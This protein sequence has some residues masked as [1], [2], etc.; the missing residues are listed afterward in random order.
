MRYHGYMLRLSLFGLAC[1]VVLLGLGTAIPIVEEGIQLDQTASSASSY[2]VEVPPMPPSCEI[3][4][5]PQ[6]ISKGEEVSIAWVAKNADSAHLTPSFGEVALSDGVFFSPQV[7][8]V[9]MLYV[10]SRFGEAACSTYVT[11]L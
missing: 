10:S 7:S 11:V 9:Y 6:T 4:A 2:V 8:E 3:S 1:V 5:H